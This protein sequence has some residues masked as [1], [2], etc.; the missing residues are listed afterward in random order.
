MYF[1]AFPNT[2]APEYG[3]AYALGLLLFVVALAISLLTMKF[4]KSAE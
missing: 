4:V 2:G 3:Y 1:K